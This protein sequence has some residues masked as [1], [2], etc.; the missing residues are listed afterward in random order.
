[1]DS[2]TAEVEEAEEGEDEKIIIF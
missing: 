2:K 1:M